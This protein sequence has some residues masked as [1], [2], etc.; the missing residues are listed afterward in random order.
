MEAFEGGLL[1]LSI[2]R[3]GPGGFCEQTFF[4]VVPDGIRRDTGSLC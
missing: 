3:V 2:A 1:V 4:L